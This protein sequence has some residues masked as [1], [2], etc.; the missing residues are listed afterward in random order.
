MA[1]PGRSGAGWSGCRTGG[2]SQRSRLAMVTFPSVVPHAGREPLGGVLGGQA[3]QMQCI[4]HGMSSIDRLTN[5]ANVMDKSFS[6]KL[7]A[8]NCKAARRT[9]HQRPFLRR[10][11]CSLPEVSKTVQLGE[12]LRS[13][14]PIYSA[15]HVTVWGVCGF[16]MGVGSGEN[17]AACGRWSAVGSVCAE[18]LGLA[19]L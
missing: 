9:A 17:C 5:P 14:W 10:R 16:G 12:P 13:N 18:R 19:V 2:R 15:L 11:G 4:R 1:R 3:R 6:V 8:S 7:S